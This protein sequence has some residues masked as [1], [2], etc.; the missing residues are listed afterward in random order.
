MHKGEIINNSSD[1][2]IAKI[3][4]YILISAIGSGNIF[5]VKW[6]PVFKVPQNP[7]WIHLFSLYLRLYKDF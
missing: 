2:R 4:R 5:F 6:K 1:D 3:N 7:N